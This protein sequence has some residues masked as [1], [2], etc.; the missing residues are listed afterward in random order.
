MLG[1]APRSSDQGTTKLATVPPAQLM[2]TIQQATEVC[3]AG[4]LGAQ[5]QVPAPI[6]AGSGVIGQLDSAGEAAEGSMDYSCR[7]PQALAGSTVLV[8]VGSSSWESILACCDCADKAWNL[9][10]LTPRAGCPGS[11]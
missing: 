4:D 10:P 7:N 11:A 2:C 8:S 1:R 9:T 3:G 5:S 6:L